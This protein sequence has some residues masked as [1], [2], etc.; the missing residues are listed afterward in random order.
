[1]LFIEENKKLSL[2]FLSYQFPEAT[3]STNKNY[4]HDANWLNCKIVFCENEYENS[5][6]DPCL[7]TSELSELIIGISNVVYGRNSSYF[8]DFLEP[9]LEITAEKI[10]DKI[11]FTIQYEYDSTKDD[12]LWIVTSLL[13]MEQAEKFIEELKEFQR[14]YPER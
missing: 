5:M 3:P 12:A 9:Y 2:S 4:N 10:E 1:M 8:S 7:T 14:I 11:K 13:E 6:V